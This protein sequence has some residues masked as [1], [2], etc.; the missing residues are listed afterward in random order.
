MTSRNREL[1]VQR[2]QEVVRGQ[3]HWSCVRQTGVNVERDVDGWTFTDAFASI[4]PS[5]DDVLAGLERLAYDPEA[6]ADWASFI[7]SASPL[8]SLESLGEDAGGELILEALW[9]LNF[10]GVLSVPVQS[11]IEAAREPR[12]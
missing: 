4:A 9:D 8:I 6:L 1:L 3:E 5:K 10:E 12:L 7:L 2:L 11:L